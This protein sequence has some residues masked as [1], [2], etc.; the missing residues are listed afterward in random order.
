[1]KCDV[2]AKCKAK[3]QQKKLTPA[4]IKAIKDEKYE[5]LKQV[6][7]ERQSWHD[8]ISRSKNT[9]ECIAIY[10][11]GMDQEKTDI[12]RLSATDVGTFGSTMKVRFEHFLLILFE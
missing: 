4:E 2:C 12:P 11:D 9:T 10:L 6:I 7:G 3:R 5:H 8:R 1:V